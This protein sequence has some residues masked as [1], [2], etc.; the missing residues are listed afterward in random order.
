MSIRVVI[1]T[2]FL[3]AAAVAVPQVTVKLTSSTRCDGNGTVSHYPNGSCVP[4]APGDM[5]YT[6][7]PVGNG[8]HT[9]HSCVSEQR[10]SGYACSN[11]LEAQTA[12]VCGVCQ[13]DASLVGSWVDCTTSKQYFVRKSGCD[14]Y[15]GNCKSEHKVWYGCGRDWVMGVSPQPC[16]VV[17]L[18]G[19]DRFLPTLRYFPAGTCTNDMLYSCPP[20][21]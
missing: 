10:W 6:C 5:E 4:L 21:Q 13:H 2:A 9:T 19:C 16:Q 14:R 7:L 12:S 18:Q 11:T 20:P 15:C 3:A 8:T 17:R 1:A